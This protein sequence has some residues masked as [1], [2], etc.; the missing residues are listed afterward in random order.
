MYRLHQNQ[1]PINN[2]IFQP[3]I[4]LFYYVQSKPIGTC[5]NVQGHPKIIDMQSK[6][7]YGSCT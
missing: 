3:L 6:Q 2:H 5:N 7:K 4:R 1:L